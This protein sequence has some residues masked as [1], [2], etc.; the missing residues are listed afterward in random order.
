[1]PRTARFL[2]PG[3]PPSPNRSWGRSWQAGARDVE[4]W[5]NRAGIALHRALK[6]RTWD[7]RPFRRA[8]VTFRFFYPDK[9]HRDPDNAM[10]SVKRLWDLFRPSDLQ[11]RYGQAPF[12]FWDDD[13]EHIPVATVEYGGVDRKSPRVEITVVEIE[14][15]EKGATAVLG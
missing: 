5:R 4:G 10:S 15:D 13:W 14:T 6:D 11:K 3:I 9:R 2:V 8:H 1:M 12:V 7:G